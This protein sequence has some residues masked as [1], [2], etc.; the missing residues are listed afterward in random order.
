MHHPLVLDH[1]YGHA[2]F[3]SLFTQEFRLREFFL[4]AHS[5]CLPHLVT[6]KELCIEAPL[7]R[8]FQQVLKRL[9]SL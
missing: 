7:P 3:N 9:R 2:K 5:L 4:H 1:L 6:G 8:P